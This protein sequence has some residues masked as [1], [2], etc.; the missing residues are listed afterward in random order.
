MPSPQANLEPVREHLER[1]LASV[2]SLLSTLSEQEQAIRSQNVTAVIT[3]STSMQGE[4]LRRS[5]L[6]Q[7]REVL[8]AGLAMRIGCAPEQIT[9][10]TLAEMDPEGLGQQVR[11][12]SERLSDRVTVLQRK[13]EQVQEMLRS[14]L[15]FVSH[16]L[17]ALS[18]ANEPAEAY[19]PK[20]RAPVVASRPSLSIQA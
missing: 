14:E 16:L 5:R 20:G 7:E 2:D 9:A 3:A 4:L 15:A 17:K 12:L 19:R 8:R 18:P 10:R 1:Q 13:H 6:E 11:A